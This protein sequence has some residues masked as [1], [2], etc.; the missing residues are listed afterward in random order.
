MKS[1]GVDTYKF[2]WEKVC[3]SF[4]V[5]FYAEKPLTNW[6]SEPWPE[7]SAEAV[8]AKVGGQLFGLGIFLMILVITR[9]LDFFSNDLHVHNHHGSNYPCTECK[10]HVK[11]MN[12]LDKPKK[13]DMY[14]PN[15]IE[16][17]FPSAHPLYQLPGVTVKNGKK[18]DMHMLAVGVD[19]NMAGGGYPYHAAG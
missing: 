5:A 15:S 8:G 17:N 2:L 6:A 1:H 4:H 9:D 18:D 14:K 13:S 16:W 11:Q 19:E 12:M 7:Y 10:T 3:W